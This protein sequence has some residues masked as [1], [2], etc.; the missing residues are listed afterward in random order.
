M[1]F[2]LS[3]IMLACVVTSGVI[4]HVIVLVLLVGVVHNELILSQCLAQVEEAVEAFL[5]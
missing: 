1:A 5:L 3:L 2:P 4:N